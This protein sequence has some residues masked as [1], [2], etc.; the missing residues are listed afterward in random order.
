M[1][2]Q[3]EGRNF[4]AIS[5]ALLGVVKRVVCLPEQL[6]QV[7]RRRIIYDHA[8]ADG[9][10]H[11]AAVHFARGLGKSAPHPFGERNRPV[12]SGIV[13]HGRKLLS[14]EPAEQIA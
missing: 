14:A 7:E 8:D 4:D 11:R 6:G 9:R 2:H 3:I 10:G 1:A 5:A 12:F 13:K